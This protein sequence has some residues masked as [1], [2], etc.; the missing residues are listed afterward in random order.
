MEQRRMRGDRGDRGEFR[1]RGGGPGEIND[2][3]T[4]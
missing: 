1:A 4:H 3:E 2:G